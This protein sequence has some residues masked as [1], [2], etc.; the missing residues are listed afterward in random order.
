MAEQPRVEVVKWIDS[1]LQNGQV[2]KEDFPKP[3]IILSVG[4][5][6][7]ETPE[8]IVLARDDMGNN[9]YRGLCAIPSVCILPKDY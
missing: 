9:D 3:V 5:V 1:S 8:Y 4:F 2:D 6:I 7:E